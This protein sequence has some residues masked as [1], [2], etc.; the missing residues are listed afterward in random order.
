MVFVAF[1][2]VG[3]VLVERAGRRPLMLYSLAGVF[4]STL[5]L[6][7][8]FYMANTTSAAVNGNI[9]DPGCGAHACVGCL[10]HKACGF[11]AT[12]SACLLRERVD[13]NTSL[14]AADS[15]YASASTDAHAVSHVCPDTYS[16]LAILGMCL[17]LASFAFG[18]TS[19]PWAINAEIF[20]THLRSAGASYATATN[21]LFN[22]GVS[23][24]FL[25]LTETITS[26]GTFWLY[27]G[28]SIVSIVY[29]YYFLPETK[30]KTLEEIED[31]FRNNVSA[32]GATT[33]KH[34][35]AVYHVIQ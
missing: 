1:T 2:V 35:G 7:Q 21:W 3:L 30:G 23:L 9:T 10:E 17:Y 32:R 29:I 33:K 25:T 18:V 15:W 22:L 27:G 6:A 13:S 8:A 4:L 31:V 16:W 28:I 14:C 12:S 20:P 26:A 24:S 19:M 5:V 34:D 11:C